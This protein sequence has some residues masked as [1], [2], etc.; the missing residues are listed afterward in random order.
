LSHVP[1]QVED[2][3]LRYAK[4][5]VWTCDATL[6]ENIQTLAVD[7]RQNDAEVLALDCLTTF[8]P[9][10]SPDVVFVSTAFIHCAVLPFSPAHLGVVVAAEV[11]IDQVHNIVTGLRVDGNV[12][13]VR[14]LVL[15]H[16][17]DSEG[18]NAAMEKTLP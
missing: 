4:V 14:K 12:V 15:E 3:R 13:P 11:S 16:L 18:K 1:G 5:D 17:R 8:Q 10:T 2:S 9:V 7:G 6:N